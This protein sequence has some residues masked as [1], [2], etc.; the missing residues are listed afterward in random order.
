MVGQHTEINIL[1]TLHSVQEAKDWLNTNRTPDLLFLD[2]QLGDGT[3]FDVLESIETYPHV[4]FTTAFDQY[5]LDAFKF[6]SI[7][8][9]LKPVKVESL[10]QAVQK[11]EKVQPDVNY[12]QVLAQLK[13]DLSTK[14][15]QKFL[16]KIGQ[17]YRSVTVDDI[18]YFYSEGGS[19]YIKTKG[20]NAWIADQPLDEL[21]TLVD[22][23]LFFRVN[24]HLLVRF[25]QIQSIDTYFNNRLILQVLPEYDESVIVS[26]DKVKAFKNW[27]DS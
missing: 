11:L 12:Q 8:Y 19:T 13:T 15:K 17:Q 9:L 10:K 25:E 22:P 7:D 20:G 1:E 3:G 21:E 2:I 23:Q 27:L 6:N 24:R 16:V 26:R 18:A 5:M 4:I 14:Y